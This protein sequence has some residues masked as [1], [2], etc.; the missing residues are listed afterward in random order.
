[1]ADS[2]GMALDNEKRYLDKIAHVKAGFIFVTVRVFL[3]INMSVPK[4]KI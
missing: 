1:M 2:W 3:V 4:N